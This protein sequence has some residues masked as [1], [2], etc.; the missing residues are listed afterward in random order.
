MGVYTK[1]IQVPSKHEITLIDITDEVEKGL[2]ESGFKTG[3]VN[4]HAY[5]STGGITTIEY[6]PGL[7]GDF[8]KMI[9]RLVPKDMEYGHE[10]RWHD[11]N[12][13]SHIRSSLIGT[14]QT[15]NYIDSK[16]DL[17]I[18]QQIIYADFAPEGDNKEITMVYIGQ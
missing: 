14:A 6:E 4:V 8:S 12:G 7:I 9:E 17:E 16:L 5:R 13:H 11:G 2:Q 18:W 1:K 15:F 10:L 3:I